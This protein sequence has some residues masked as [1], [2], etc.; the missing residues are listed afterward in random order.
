[1]LSNDSYVFHSLPTPVPGVCM[2]AGSCLPPQQDLWRQSHICAVWAVQVCFV[3]SSMHPWTCHSAV[4]FSPLYPL[5]RRWT[6]SSMLWRYICVS[7]RE[8]E[9]SGL[10]VTTARSHSL[11]DDCLFSIILN[12]SLIKVVQ[13]KKKYLKHLKMLY[14]KRLQ[15]PDTHHTPGASISILCVWEY[16]LVVKCH[17]QLF[18]LQF[19]STASRLIYDNCTIK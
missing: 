14:R 13:K 18:Q 7:Q 2:W 4:L 15:K 5:T 3:C 1:M 19:T 12:T 16:L 17:C 6:I 8:R 11:S 9:D 10:T